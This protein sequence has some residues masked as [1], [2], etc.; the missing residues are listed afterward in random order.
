MSDTVFRQRDINCSMKTPGKLLFI[1]MSFFNESDFE[2]NLKTISEQT[3]ISSRDAL[4]EEESSILYATSRWLDAYSMQQ[5]QRDQAMGAVSKFN[6]CLTET[7]LTAVKHASDKKFLQKLT[8][9][10]EG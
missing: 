5:L 7:H 2:H 3:T 9:S 10:N 1:E 4:S 8:E 6:S